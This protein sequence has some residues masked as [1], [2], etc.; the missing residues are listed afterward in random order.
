M[1]SNVDD[2]GGGSEVSIPDKINDDISL[3]VCKGYPMLEEVEN[4]SAY[5]SP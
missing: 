2:A 5:S 3:D 4:K 1:L